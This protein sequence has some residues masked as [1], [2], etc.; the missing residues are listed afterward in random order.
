MLRFKIS[1]TKR[2]VA[3]TRRQHPNLPF[4]LY[5]QNRWSALGNPS[6]GPSHWKPML[7]H[8][9]R[10][11]WPP[12]PQ[13]NILRQRH[14]EIY[15]NWLFSYE[16]SLGCR[17]VGKSSCRMSKVWGKCNNKWEFGSSYNWSKFGYG[18]TE[19]HASFG[20]QTQR[21]LQLVPN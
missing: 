8:S 14:G 17:S 9:R 18:Y 4:C 6:S 20:A 15:P 7:R 19:T 21:H 10:P 2:F 16:Y 5:E 3:K 11:I 12:Q 1:G 13:T